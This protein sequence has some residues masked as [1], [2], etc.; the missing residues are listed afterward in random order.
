MDPIFIYH[1]IICLAK[2]EYLPS[3]EESSIICSYTGEAE[4]LGQAEKYM[5][6]MSGF[7][8]A[9]KH[10][11]AMIYKQQLKIRVNECCATL[12]VIE[13][14]CDDVKMCVGFKKVLKTILK[15]GNQMNDGE[16]HLG[17]TLDSLLKLQS[18][19]AFDKKT[20]ILQYVIMLIYRNDEKCL[21]FPNELTHCAEASR[22]TLDSAHQEQVA[23]KQGHEASLRI[24]SAALHQ[25][26]SSTVLTAM[27]V[28][29]SFLSEAKQMLEELS[30]KV[31]GVKLKFASVLAYFGEESGMSSQD[32]F[33]TLTAF[34]TV[35]KSGG[36]VTLQCAI[37]IHCS[38][39]I[40]QNVVVDITFFFP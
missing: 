14:A 33:S 5:K 2:Q 21:D 8:A 20:S 18:A 7:P 29:T 27:S 25:D 4:M 31:N 12:S 19:K 22:L 39:F 36:T 6:E 40:T 3:E 24:V 15:V 17:F 13:G 9:G 37:M 28:M 30:A 35:R 32:F 23:L 10:I 38:L 34:I 11:Q 26:A 1:H 16:K